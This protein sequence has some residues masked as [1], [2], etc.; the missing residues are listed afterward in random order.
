MADKTYK[1]TVTLS[2]GNTVDAGTFVAPQ[3]P[4]GPKGDTGPQGPKGDPGSGG[5]PCYWVSFEGGDVIVTLP[6]A[7]TS[8]SKRTNQGALTV[9][10]NATSHAPGSLLA[11]F[12]GFLGGCRL[13]EFAIRIDVLQMQAHILKG[14]GEQF[15]YA[16]LLQPD[17]LV[18]KPNFNAHDVVRLIDD[19]LVLLCCHKSPPAL[20]RSPWATDRLAS[21]S[22]Y[23][24][25]TSLRYDWTRRAR[26]SGHPASP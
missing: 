20:F 7:D 5:V 3:G 10:D 11:N 26:T 22:H 16:R 17:S 24:K 8:Y 18:F 21:Y 23:P 12:Q 9:I 13:I 14:T 6:T 15:G 25:L 1:M 2:N 4:Q 19:D